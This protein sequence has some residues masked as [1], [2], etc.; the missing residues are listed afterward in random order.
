MGASP[1]F[2]RFALGALV[3]AAIA[4]T[5]HKLCDLSADY[6]LWGHLFFGGEMLRL[7]TLLR[8]DTYSF[9]AA[10]HPFINHEWITEIVMA[11]FYSRAG[12]A[13]LIALRLLIVAAIIVIA[14]RIVARNSRDA[15]S[16]FVVWICFVSVLSAGISFRPQL[17]TYL[18][19]ILLADWF[20]RAD[21]LSARSLWTRMT[22]LLA[23]W[24]NLHGGF[25]LGAF[26]WIVF[27]ITSARL[28]KQLHW[29]QICAPIVATLC[30]PYG[31][32]LWFYVLRELGNPVSSEHITEWRRF[33]FQPREL[34]FMLMS[35]VALSGMYLFRKCTRYEVA[36]VLLAGLLGALSVR[37]SPLIALLGLA[38]FARGVSNGFMRFLPS[39]TSGLAIEEASP[40]PKQSIVVQYGAACAVLCLGLV[41]TGSRI[42]QEDELPLRAL[43][44]F[45]EQ[46][47]QGR[48][49]LPLHWGSVT[50]FHL[51]PQV[52]VSIDGRWATLY[53][54]SVMRAHKQFAENRKPGEWRKIL[55]DSGAEYAFVER[56]HPAVA[57]MSSDSGWK[58]IFGD[59]EM[60][61][62]AR[63]RE[64]G[65]RF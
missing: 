58:W 4:A 50:L 38:P 19:L 52:Q 54:Q 5:L 41:V 48:V 31:V 8:S 12:E 35:L 61:V 64:N 29:W 45:K 33:S 62:L 51:A 47:L 3:L 46:R 6:D 2:N 56:H 44:F 39:F 20:D 1:A 18:F 17:V 9:T 59:K 55:E 30:T 15:F 63:V 14:W 23:L 25:A 65:P 36:A 11:W 26:L 57:E 43:R 42:K 34:P 27:V 21:S 10:G 28:R 49:W 60:A 37:H 16:R 32:E 7:G 22:L 40:R 53:P 24:S 13:G